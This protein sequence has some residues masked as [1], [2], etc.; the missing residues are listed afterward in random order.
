MPYRKG[1]KFT[2][3]L[4]NNSTCGCFLA[5]FV[6]ARTQRGR[7]REGG[8]GRRSGKTGE[9]GGG[10][11]TERERERQTDREDYQKRTVTHAPQKTATERKVRVVSVGCRVRHPLAAV[12][13]E[14]RATEAAGHLRATFYSL[15]VDPDR[16][17]KS[18]STIAM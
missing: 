16:T 5:Q 10:V 11:K 4:F 2:A 12:V 3:I 13:V 1:I 15:N 17:S 7:R 6:C 14:L 18:E 9:R 8:C